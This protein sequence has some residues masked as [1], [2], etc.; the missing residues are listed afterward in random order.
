MLKE[1]DLKR[2]LSFEE[3]KYFLS[4]TEEFEVSKYDEDTIKIALIF[5]GDIITDILMYK[6][7]LQRLIR[8]LVSLGYDK[9]S[10]ISK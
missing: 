6:P 7:T 8:N 4:E 3:I 1:L 9:R 2:E 10:I 5:G